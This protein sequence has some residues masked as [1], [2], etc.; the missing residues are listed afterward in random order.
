[1]AAPTYIE[2]VELRK[3]VKQHLSRIIFQTVGHYANSLHPTLL[4]NKVQSRI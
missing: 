3:W 1:M 4:A 2:G